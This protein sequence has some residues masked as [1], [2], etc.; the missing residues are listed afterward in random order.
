MPANRTPRVANGGGSAADVP[1]GA[2]GTEL[3][4]QTPKRPSWR[5]VLKVHPACEL[6]PQLSTDELKELGEDIR[7][8]RLQQRAKVIRDGDGFA[9]LDGR[10]RLDAIEAAGLTIKVFE[11][12]TSST[13]NNKFFEVVE[14]DDPYAYVMSANVKRRHLSGEDKRTL[15]AKLL[16]LNPNQS[17]L[18]ISKMIGVDDKT[19]A[20]VRRELEGRSEIP[21]VPTRPDTKGRNQPA[22]RQATKPTRPAGITTSTNTVKPL[23]ADDTNSETPELRSMRELFERGRERLSPEAAMAAAESVDPGRIVATDRC[24]E[25]WPDV[26]F[27]DDVQKPRSNGNGV[28]PAASAEARKAQVADAETDVAAEA[29]TPVK[30]PTPPDLAA[31]PENAEPKPNQVSKEALW[32]WGWLRDFECEDVAKP[33]ILDRDPNDIVATLTPEMLDDVHRLAPQVA[34]WL[35]QISVIPSCENVSGRLS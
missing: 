19:V 24:R 13:P 31:V 9:V 7:K 15:I 25:L 5:D 30:P 23:P 32:L 12:S 6:F 20:S 1:S 28:D 11:S 29:T 14:V 10:S 21:N 3:A 4:G 17:N 2:I 8:H 35:K 33:A 34:K 26:S 16:V 18:A 22:K 27:D